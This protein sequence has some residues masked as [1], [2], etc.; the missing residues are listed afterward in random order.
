MAATV[1]PLPD[2]P[3]LP[4]G[5]AQGRLAFDIALEIGLFVRQRRLGRCGTAETGFS[6]SEDPDT[7]LAPDLAFVQSGRLPQ[8]NPRGFVR[9]ALDLVLETRSPGGRP[10][11]VAKEGRLDASRRARELP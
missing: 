4:A 7:V 2:A 8:A 1:V 10:R 5:N 6:P 9:A 11:E 3:D